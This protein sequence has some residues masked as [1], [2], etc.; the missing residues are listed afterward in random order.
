MI[1]ECMSTK[2]TAKVELGDPSMTQMPSLA[3]KNPQPRV[4]L[5][6]ITSVVMLIYPYN[7]QKSVTLKKKNKKKPYCIIYR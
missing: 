7:V 4:N 1:T 2:H 5:H 6:V 3:E